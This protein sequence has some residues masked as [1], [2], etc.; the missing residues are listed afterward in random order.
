[1]RFVSKKTSRLDAAR[2]W[3]RFG[4]WWVVV[5][6]LLALGQVCNA[7]AHIVGKP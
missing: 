3:L 4:G 1:M 7:I 5:G 6:G 2:E